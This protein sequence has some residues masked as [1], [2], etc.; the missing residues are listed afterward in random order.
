MGEG[1]SRHVMLC[2]Y[3]DYP[4]RLFV[5]MQTHIFVHK[6]CGGWDGSTLR[7]FEVGHGV[8]IRLRSLFSRLAKFE[9]VLT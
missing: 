2:L 9:C 3:R 8:H 4:Q 6:G 5:V 7:S 1:F